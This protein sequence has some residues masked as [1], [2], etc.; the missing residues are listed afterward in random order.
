MI[1]VFQRLT[2]HFYKFASCSKN[3]LSFVP[4]ISQSLPTYH[5]LL[6]KDFS[7]LKVL[8]V[9]PGSRSCTQID[10]CVILDHLFKQVLYENHIEFVN[11][12]FFILYLG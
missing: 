8:E 10:N 4:Q 7:L 5:F 11:R 9:L 6:G 12:G 3:S 2:Y 1:V